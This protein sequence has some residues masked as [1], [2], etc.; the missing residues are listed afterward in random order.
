MKKAD[1]LDKLATKFHKVLTPKERRDEE[2]GIKEYIVEVFD[3]TGINSLKRHL[4][5]F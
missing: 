1:L 3:R 5:C 4:L 2:G